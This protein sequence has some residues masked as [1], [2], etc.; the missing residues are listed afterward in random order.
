MTPATIAVIPLAVMMLLLAAPIRAQSSDWPPKQCVIL[1][2]SEEPDHSRADDK[3][4][5]GIEEIVA[6]LVSW[7]IA[8]TGWAAGGPP[9]LR[10]ISDEDLAN[11]FA[12]GNNNA[13][14]EALYSHKD[15][16]IYLP[17]GWNKNNLRD[18]SALLHELVHHLQYL[19]KVEAS[20]ASEYEMD[21]YKLQI[22]WL[23]EQGVEDPL[24][25]LGVNMAFIKFITACLASHT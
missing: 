18:R 2:A 23:H 6:P 8:K 12:G 13:H 22:D 24:K 3:K 20:C 10:F 9:L 21:A 19:N 1:Y 5:I 7:I 16:I 14:I 4:G 25:F 15:H 17:L 11:R